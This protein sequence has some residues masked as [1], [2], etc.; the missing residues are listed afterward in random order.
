MFT[1]PNLFEGTY[2]T[3]CEKKFFLSLRKRSLE[4][5]TVATAI[6]TIISR[7]TKSKQKNEKA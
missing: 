4:E 7:R 3:K 1:R 5:I 6:L 2:Q